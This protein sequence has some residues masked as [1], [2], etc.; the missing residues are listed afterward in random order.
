MKKKVFIVDDRSEFRKLTRMFLINKYDIETAD[1]G[2]Q[3]MA[4]L[5][6]GYLPDLIVSDLMMPNLDGAG[7]LKQLKSSDSF[8][9]IP[10][11]ILSSI[12]K[13]QEKVKLIRLGADDYLEKPFNPAELLVRI[14]KLIG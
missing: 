5:Q 4:L 9:N 2:I 8:K 6:K 13:S 10:F 11:I 14:E 12:D 3:G 7:F 1:D